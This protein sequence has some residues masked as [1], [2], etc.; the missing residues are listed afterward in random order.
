MRILVATDA[1]LPQVNGVVRSMQAMAEHGRALGAELVFLAPD[2]F[3][4]IPMPG[5]SEIRLA[6]ARRRTVARLMR[7]AGADHVHIATEG[8]IGFAARAA[9]L[10]E[11]WPFTTAYHTR[12]PE[13]VSRRLPVPESWVYRLLRRFHAPAA[14]TMVATP[15][16]EADLAARGFSGLVRWSRGVDTDLYRPRPDL[17]R[18]HPGPVFLHVGRLAVEKNV[19]G[20]L[21]LDLPGTKLVVGDGP[22]RARLEAAYPQARFLGALEGE[23]LAQTYSAA[24]V[25]VFPSRTDT[26]GLVLLEALASGLPVAAH[27]VMG[28][29]DVL[30]QSGCGV[31]DEDL[32][33]AALAALAIPPE[34]CRRHALGFDW[35]ESARQFLDAVRAGGAIGAA[36]SSTGTE[37]A[38]ARDAPVGRF[39]P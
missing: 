32:G 23:A 22:A 14:A 18:P 21:R 30:G 7:E 13:Y 36:S 12:F 29:L 31:M 27:P 20:F 28:P 33:R 9:C 8:P 19:E 15:T 2:R 1:W 4:S 11:G 38:R 10:R 26:F 3:R 34:L 16:L 39:G 24:D 35:A 17:P 37:P 25:F 5:Y 6:F